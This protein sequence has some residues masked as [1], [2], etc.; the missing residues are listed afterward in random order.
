MM[1]TA[2][3]WLALAF[4]ITASTLFGCGDPGD[5]LETAEL[6]LTTSR[7]LTF[8]PTQRVMK[9]DCGENAPS[10]VSP[11]PACTAFNAR[12]G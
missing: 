2:R 11:S 12:D 8:G 4:A 6:E 9:K 3:S 5:G 1:N 10:T 7:T